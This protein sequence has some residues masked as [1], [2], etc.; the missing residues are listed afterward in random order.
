MSVQEGSFWDLQVW[1]LTVAQ[2]LWMVV[3]A[4]VAL[5]LDRVIARYV[6]KLAKRT[7]LE[8]RVTN[9]VILTSRILILV[10]A[11]ASVT[12]VG[13][14]PTEWFVAFS[15]IGGAAVGFA[16]HKPSGTPYPGSTF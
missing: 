3:I 13:G 4:A 8:R 5:I 12:R 1:G 11:L 10:G 2:W 9:G 15:A 14:V 6:R 7:R 16:S